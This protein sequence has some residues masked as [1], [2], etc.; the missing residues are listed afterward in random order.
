[1]DDVNAIG[2]P[3]QF[4]PNAVGFIQIPPERFDHDIHQA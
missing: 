2:V 4:T 1:M 3:V